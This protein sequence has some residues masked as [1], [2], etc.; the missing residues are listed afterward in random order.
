MKIEKR[1]QIAKRFLQTVLWIDDDINM[2]DDQDG[3]FQKFFKPA[4]MTISKEGMICQLFGFTSSKGEEDPYGSEGISELEI[5]NGILPRADI[6]IVD[7]FLGTNDPSNSTK[8]IN[9]ILLCKG[10]RFC[11]ILSKE[12]TLEV[13][14]V[15]MYADRLENKGSYLCNKVGNKFFILLSKKDFQD[16]KMPALIPT[17]IST[18]ADTYQDYLHW[19]AIEIMANVKDEI[20]TLLENLPKDTD[21]A[22]MAD[23]VLDDL[24]TSLDF[25]ASAIGE[26]IYD[27]VTEMRLDTLLTCS[28]QFEA[29]AI[30]T[31]LKNELLSKATEEWN[32]LPDKDKLKNPIEEALKNQQVKHNVIKA[33]QLNKNYNCLTELLEQRSLDHHIS[34]RVFQGAVYRDPN[35]TDKILVCVS[36]ACD[37]NTKD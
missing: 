21:R 14:F 25:A 30:F 4:S 7:W 29:D 26:D 5:I 22:F 9:E 10:T 34:P 8:I 17:I 31:T 18:I 3:H 37:C 19:L 20:P 2:G 36:Q 33:L 23:C 16:G 1:Q 11:V 35:E 6:V 12:A 27:V 28:K 32:I 13:D 15:R 24:K